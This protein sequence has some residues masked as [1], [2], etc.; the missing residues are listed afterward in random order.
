MGDMGRGA[1][2]FFPTTPN[3]ERGGAPILAAAGWGKIF[4]NVHQRAARNRCY[5]P[6]SEIVDSSIGSWRQRGEKRLRFRDLGKFRG[7]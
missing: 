4:P 5:G 1:G 2:N 3:F 6:S 7:R